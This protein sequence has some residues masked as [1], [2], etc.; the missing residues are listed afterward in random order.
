MI[1]CASCN[2]MY[3]GLMDIQINGYYFVVHKLKQ[4]Y[5]N[6]GLNLDLGSSQSITSVIIAV[7]KTDRD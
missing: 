5:N 6:K 7:K 3:K 4:P 1:M 2:K